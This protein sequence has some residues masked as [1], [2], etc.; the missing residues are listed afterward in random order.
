MVL[1][2]FLFLK[3]IYFER[4]SEN[5]RAQPGEGQREG[6][7][8]PSRLRTISAEPDAGLRATNCET[9]T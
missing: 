2:S 3:F 7:R 9:V 1:F 6:G 5:E 4:Q 8:I